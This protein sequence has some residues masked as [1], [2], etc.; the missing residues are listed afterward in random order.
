MLIQLD[1]TSLLALCSIPSAFTGLCFWLIQKNITK[2]DAKH[3]KQEEARKKNE[4]LLI[5]CIGA[6]FALGEA[7]AKAIRDNKSNGELSDAL[8]YAQKVKHEH[9]DFLNEQGV[10][11][12]F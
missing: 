6:V 4:V 11:Y 3:D 10:E 2:R 5:K 8:E 12:L 1:L 9:K 7:T